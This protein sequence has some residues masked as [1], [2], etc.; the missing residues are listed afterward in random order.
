MGLVQLE[1]SRVLRIWQVHLILHFTQ[2]GRQPRLPYLW[3]RRSLSAAVFPENN[4]VSKTVHFLYTDV[5]AQERNSCTGKSSAAFN[6]ANDL[7]PPE[8]GGTKPHLLASEVTVR[9]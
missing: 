6:A 3:A 7:A 8:V 1:L 2:R 9:N 5:G 4:Q